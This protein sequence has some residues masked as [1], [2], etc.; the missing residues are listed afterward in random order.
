MTPHAEKAKLFAAGSVIT[1]SIVRIYAPAAAALEDHTFGKHVVNGDNIEYSS[2]DTD[3]VIAAG[4]YLEG[5]LLQ[6]ETKTSAVVVYYN[7][8]LSVS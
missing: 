7:G 5:P 3:I 8:S 1:G 2:S 6:C 4:S